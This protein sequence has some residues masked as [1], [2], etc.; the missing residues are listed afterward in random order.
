MS[1]SVESLRVRGFADEGGDGIVGGDGVTPVLGGG[2]ASSPSKILLQPLGGAQ[3]GELR[4]KVDDIKRDLRAHVAALEQHVAHDLRSEKRRA[5]RKIKLD[6]R[7]EGRKEGAGSLISDP[8]AKALYLKVYAKNERLR[9]EVN[10]AEQHFARISA[11]KKQMEADLTAQIDALGARLA[12]EEEAHRHDVAT[13]QRKEAKLTEELRASETERERER[14][15][16]AQAAKSAKEQFDAAEREHASDV[17]RLKHEA[18]ERLER[19]IVRAETAEAKVAEEDKRVHELEAALEKEKEAVLEKE[20][21]FSMREAEFEE[22]VSELRQASTDMVLDEQAKHEA[23]M[24]KAVEEIAGLHRKVEELEQAQSEIQEQQQAPV[25]A[26]S[27]DQRPDSQGSQ[28]SV[29]TDGGGWLN[30]PDKREQAPDHADEILVDMQGRLK[31]AK[32]SV[33]EME[34]GRKK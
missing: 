7:R 5:R 32:R 17:A 16:G 2:L 14:E 1:S 4:Q 21:E 27:P 11:E 9:D 8:K 13:G 33:K 29:S 28:L 20:R 24:A 22:E 26:P 15:R 31:E 6:L 3:E 18:R 12:A 34:Q 23:Q 30:S 10:V 25:Q 19:E